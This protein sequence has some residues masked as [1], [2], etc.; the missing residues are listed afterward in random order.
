MQE[1]T[2]VSNKWLYAFIAIAVAVNFSGLFVTIM[3]PDGALYA[4]IAKTMVLKNNYSDLFVNGQDWLDKP[5]FPFWI[6]AFSF[7]IFGFTTWAYKLPAILFVMMGAY[8]TYRLGSELYNKRIALW[9]VLILLTAEHL[10][11]SNNDVRAEPY[12]TGL[13][14][15][16]VYFFYKG[17]Q[18]RWF[19]NIILASLFAACAV[20][21]KGVFAVIPVATAIFGHLLIRKQWGLLFD[22]RWLVAIITGSVF[23][24]PELWCLYRQFDIHPEKIVFGQTHVS[25][26]KFF[27]WDSQFGRFFNDGPIKKSSGDPSFFLHTTLWAYLPWSLML[28]IG[29]V[30]FFRTKQ[31][32]VK[33]K[34][35][36]WYCLCGAAFTFLVFSLSKFQLPHY[37]TILFPFFSI[38]AAQYFYS[39]EQKGLKVI[40]GIQI[41]VMVV[42][43]LI[44][45]L[46]HYFFRPENISM[47]AVTLLV[48]CMILLLAISLTVVGRSK[49]LLQTCAVAFFVNLYFNLAYYP[50]L[51]TYQSD[52]TAAIWVNNHNPQK[53]PLVQ[54]LNGTSY[55][56][57]FYANQV[58]YP[59]FMEDKLPAKPYLLFGD[60]E[61]IDELRE[62]GIPMKHLQ[63]FER[64]RITM[65]N[66]TFLN[67]RTR[68]EA[69]KLSE[70]VLLQ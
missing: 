56:M 44:L 64:F 12:L 3:E 15:A 27:F 50:K 47:L 9:A 54:I 40:R 20:M 62:K 25:G 39:L 55:A 48:G 36:E 46:L 24:L 53:L 52:S 13:I 38:L 33:G 5:H 21:T 60:K 49:I 58:V 68:H 42:M 1:N 17:L 29:I 45:A 2:D 14:I 11:I 31:N 34:E 35:K 59:S 19:W 37:I 41:F 7:N 57:P 69:V 67:R 23:I 65:V 18:R 51:L 32:P 61:A 43:T 70:L 4:S 6:A 26:L 22:V 8:Y 16:S 10:I 66:K 63:T 28:Y 30:Q